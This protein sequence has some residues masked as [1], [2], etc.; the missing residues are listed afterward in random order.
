MSWLQ[1]A[2][3]HLA[4]HWAWTVDNQIRAR[5]NLEGAMS[6]TTIQGLK[7]GIVGASVAGLATAK[8]LRDRGA[9][10]KLFERSRAKLEERG[11]GI[12]MDP[13]IVPLLGSLKGWLI[14]GR[15]VIGTSGRPLWT[16]PASKFLTAWSEV[17]SS[18]HAH[19]P[20]SIIYRGHEVQQCESVEQGAVMHYGQRPSE[21]F[22]LVVGA[23]GPGSVVRQAVVPEFEPQ[24]LG[25]VAIRGHIGEASLPGACDKIRQ[26][27][28][29]PGLINC[30]GP[31]THIVAYW[32]PSP[33][34][35]V[36]NWMWYR[37]V[38]SRNL[39]EFMSDD[40]GT[41]H[42]WSLPPGM[43][44]GDRRTQLL[45]EITDVFPAA[46][47]A[48]ACA[49]D[50]MY[51]QAI[52]K[53]VP[54]RLIHN[55]LILVGDAAHVSVPHIGAGSSFAVQDAASLA[56][57]LGNEDSGR[58]LDAWAAQRHDSTQSAMNIAANLGHALQHEDH[59]WEHWSPSDFD[60]WWNNLAGN[61]RL[62][63]D[64]E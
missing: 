50:N 34:G 5:S 49:T 59:D 23:D 51:L 21:W 7:V 55:N 32:I 17:Y 14:E 18:L 38:D 43:L 42:H 28:D 40:T 60:K 1:C 62:Y 26:W 54:A 57:A 19:V 29:S 31:R 16:R 27:A 8:F 22:D 13:D 15:I 6:L 10:V 2:P 52:Y 39:S 35:K 30:Y 45:R 41:P 63:F 61:R 37:N 4:V 33:T 46:F 9:D 36:L 3:K 20:E 25:Y 48:L 11:G 56:E 47:S 64:H 24:Y 58:G 12:A 44:P 53:G